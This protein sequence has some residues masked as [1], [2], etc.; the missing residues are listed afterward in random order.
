LP[1]VGRFGTYNYYNSDRCIRAAM[2]LAAG[3]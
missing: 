1:V 3:F 2:D